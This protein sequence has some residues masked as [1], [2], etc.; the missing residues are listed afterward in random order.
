MRFVDS[1]CVVRIVRIL[2][3]ITYNYNV[4]DDIIIILMLH[5]HL[6]IIVIVI[7][8]SVE[9]G[10]FV[11]ILNIRNNIIMKLKFVFVYALFHIP[12]PPL[13]GR[14]LIPTYEM[15]KHNKLLFKSYLSVHEVSTYVGADCLNQYFFE[16]KT[17]F[18]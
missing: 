1:T 17:P 10:V 3:I 6:H 7:V 16:H 4:Y 15:L 18:T 11:L 5:Y 2:S 8:F 14:F 9:V 12:L 13:S